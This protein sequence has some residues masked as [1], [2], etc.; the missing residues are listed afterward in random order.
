MPSF[1]EELARM[2]W[3]RDN[4]KVSPDERVKLVFPR[5]EAR[6]RVKNTEGRTRL[7]V[8]LDTPESYSAF[9]AQFARFKEVT[10][11]PQIA[12]QIMLDL[13]AALPDESIRSLANAEREEKK[14]Y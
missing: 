13:L 12:Y 14:P 3:L 5:L 10:G 8:Q 11:N 1:A 6:R 4:K 9:S 2:I 7:I